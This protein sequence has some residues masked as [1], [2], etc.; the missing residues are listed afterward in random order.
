MCLA[1]YGVVKHLRWKKVGLDGFSES[2]FEVDSEEH[3]FC[4]GPVKDLTSSRL[5]IPQV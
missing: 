5:M 3:A 1:F 4:N 2:L